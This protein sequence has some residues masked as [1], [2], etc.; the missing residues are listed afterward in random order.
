MET[1]I[2]SLRSMK[3]FGESAFEVHCWLD[4]YWNGE[5]GNHEHRS[6]FHNKEGIEKGVR[7]F[8]EWARKHIELHL[9]DDGVSY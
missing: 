7:K 2:H 5:V 3:E 6:V 8:G 9:E 4:S 1:W